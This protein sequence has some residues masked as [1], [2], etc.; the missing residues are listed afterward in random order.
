MTESLAA[1]LTAV[2]LAAEVDP[3]AEG[4][5]AR[6][7]A[8]PSPDPAAVAAAVIAA[9]PAGWRF[10]GRSH[11]HRDGALVV[12]C[13]LAAPPSPAVVDLAPHTDAAA[14]DGHGDPAAR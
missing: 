8:A 12:E 11:A 13:D 3:L 10:V 9:L 2:G 6:V 4:A 5:R 14:S 1:A 7:A